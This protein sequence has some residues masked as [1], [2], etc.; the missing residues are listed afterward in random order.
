V[1][2]TLLLIRHAATAISPHEAASSWRLSA[3]GRA[4]CAPLAACL[5]RY[6]PAAIVSSLE[7][8]AVETASAVAAALG[9]ASATAPGLHEHDRAGVPVLE[10]G[11]WRDRVRD[12]FARPDELT[13]GR[14]TA[15][16]AAARFAGAVDAVLAAHPAGD[17]AVVAHGTV[18]S[19][20]ASMHN[21]DIDGFA[22]WETLGMPALLALDA[23]GFR[24][25]ESILQIA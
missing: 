22:L 6:R 24:L 16:D 1:T 23:P 10:P 25:R 15:R 2:R 8:K 12:L 7:P 9:L 14:E 18:I 20:F 4:A 11:A 5:A 21:R 17:V 13:L 19:L 3:A